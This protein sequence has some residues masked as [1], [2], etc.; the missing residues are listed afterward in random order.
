LFSQKSSIIRCTLVVEVLCP[1]Y[2]ILGDGSVPVFLVSFVWA[3][4]VVELPDLLYAGLVG[5]Y[6][7]NLLVQDSFLEASIQFSAPLFG[8]EKGHCLI[9]KGCVVKKLVIQ[10]NAT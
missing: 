5:A 10:V 8:G 9:M 1:S 7:V 6:W 2:T 4:R 3:V